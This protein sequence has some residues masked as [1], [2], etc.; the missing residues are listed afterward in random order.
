MLGEGGKHGLRESEEVGEFDNVRGRQPLRRSQRFVYF[1]LC[2]ERHH[3]VNFLDAK[4][5]DQEHACPSTR[6]RKM[7]CALI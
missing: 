2:H 6:T 4:G 3:S 1:V 7:L 5:S